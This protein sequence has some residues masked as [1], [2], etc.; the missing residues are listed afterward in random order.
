MARYVTVAAA[1]LG[2]VQREHTR[3]QVVARLWAGDRLVE[4]REARPGTDG[5][6]RLRMTL[7]PGLIR[8]RFE[9][10]GIQAGRSRVIHSATN[11]VCG[12]AYLIDGQSNAVATDWGPDRPDFQ[13]DW[14]RSFGSMGHEPAVSGTW[15]NAVHRAPAHISKEPHPGTPRQENKRKRR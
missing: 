11:L 4:R 6:F 3:E 14:I 12:D 13:S 9:M 7:K 5:S 8:Y 15:G 10:A 2:P 1:Q